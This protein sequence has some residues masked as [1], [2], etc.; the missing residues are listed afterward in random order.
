M[1]SW[2]SVVP[3]SFT[4]VQEDFGI[5]GDNGLGTIIAPTPGPASSVHIRRSLI[6]PRI[7]EGS[8]LTSPSPQKEKNNNM[9]HLVL[10]RL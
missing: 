3:R 6:F 5:D 9:V 8:L 7:L 2:V 1:I 10:E 4:G